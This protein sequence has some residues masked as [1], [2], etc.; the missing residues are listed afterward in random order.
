M[1]NSERKTFEHVGIDKRN[2]NH[3]MGRNTSVYLHF[4]A[5]LY[6]KQPNWTQIP[7]KKTRL[8]VNTNANVGFLDGGVARKVLERKWYRLA[9][10]E[11]TRQNSGDYKGNE[12]CVRQLKPAEKRCSATSTWQGKVIF[13]SGT[14]QEFFLGGMFFS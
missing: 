2:L 10:H 7:H 14:F 4:K 5:S 3:S 1:I 8:I 6:V 13:C 12:K 11:P 9:G